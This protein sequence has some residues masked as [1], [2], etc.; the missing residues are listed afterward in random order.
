MTWK[1]LNPWKTRIPGYYV[2]IVDSGNFVR[3]KKSPVS[4]ISGE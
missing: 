4:A 1:K 2:D 3:L